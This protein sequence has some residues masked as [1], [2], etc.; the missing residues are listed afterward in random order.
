MK[1]APD[2]MGSISAKSLAHVVE[3]AVVVGPAIASCLITTSTTLA[4][5]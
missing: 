5:R 2:I 4:F 1:A 3:D